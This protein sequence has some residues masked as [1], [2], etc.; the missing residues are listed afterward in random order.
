MHWKISS[1]KWRPF[2]LGLNVLSLNTGPVYTRSNVVIIQPA[3]TL[4]PTGAGPPAGTALSTKLGIILQDFTFFYGTF[5]VNSLWLNYA[6]WRLN[7]RW[8]IDTRASLGTN[9]NE[10]WIKVDFCHRVYIFVAIMHNLACLSSIL[11]PSY[12]NFRSNGGQT[13]SNRGH[14]PPSSVGRYYNEDLGHM[15]IQLL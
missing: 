14:S 11:H 13:Q 6:I 2:C 4:A 9:V 8:L 3:H 7:Q 15:S 10:I 5:T 12:R 1:A